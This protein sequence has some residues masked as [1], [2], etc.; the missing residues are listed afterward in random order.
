MSNTKPYRGE[1]YYEVSVG[2]IKRRL[3]LVKVAEKIW[4]ASD[5]DLVLGDVEF[6]EAA[7]RLL[8]DKIKACE[9]EL[10]VAPEAKSLALAYEVAKQLG[11]KRFVV[12]RK[13]RKS[14]MKSVIV[15]RVRSITTAREQILLLTREDAEQL[16]NRRVCIIDD[17]V[18]TG[19]TI[20]A[21]ER[22]VK[23]AGGVVVCKA[24]IWIEG[25][26]CLNKGI[27]HLLTLP[28]FVEFDESQ[29]K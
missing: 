8:A 5:A 1:E 6:I 10:I 13:E 22:L 23:R 20:E 4:I 9:P 12:A 2:N 28:L 14:Y 29:S 26:W 19:S 11:L 16:K 21:L 18:S 3:P 17:V 25:D 24:A 15:E 27:L 7:A